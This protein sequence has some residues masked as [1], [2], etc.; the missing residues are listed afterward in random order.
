MLMGRE[1]DRVG[2]ENMRTTYVTEL[3]IKRLKEFCNANYNVHGV[4]WGW[5]YLGK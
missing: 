4:D 5:W 1:I 2:H 3:Y